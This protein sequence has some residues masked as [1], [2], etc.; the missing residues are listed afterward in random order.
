MRI[1]QNPQLRTEIQVTLKQLRQAADYADDLEIDRWQ[2]AIPLRALLNLGTSESCLRWIVLRGLAEHA[3][4]TTT[5]KHAMRKFSRSASTAFCDTTCFVLTESG[6]AVLGKKNT[7]APPL[8]ESLSVQDGLPSLGE[9]AVAFSSVKRNHVPRARTP[10]SATQIILPD[11]DPELR[12]LRLGG[13][14]VKQ[15]QQ[16]SSNQILVLS[17]FQELGWPHRMDDPL[18]PNKGLDPKR[19]LRFTIWRLNNHQ[20]R[21][22]IQFLGDGTGQGI[23]W[24]RIS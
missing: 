23:C 2:F 7:I 9:K 17:A 14:V 11:W 20:E 21:R 18:V 4:E 10:G 22:L 16:R 5:F 19:R 12:V 1:P 6:A 24:Q 3:R 13:Q 8:Y 15:F